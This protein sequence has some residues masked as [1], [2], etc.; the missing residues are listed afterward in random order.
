MQ[1][2]TKLV[3]ME[4]EVGS[5]RRDGDRIVISSDP[6]K[7]MPAEVYMTPKDVVGMIK[8]SLNLSVISYILLFPFLYIKCLKSDSG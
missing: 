8:A 5:I 3:K 7:S 6:T 2:N 4:L 1:V